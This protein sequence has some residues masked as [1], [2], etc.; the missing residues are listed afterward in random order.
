M[1]VPVSWLR[2]YVAFDLPLAALAEKLVLSGLEVD[3]IVTRGAPDV[4]GNHGTFRIGR[5]VE[6]ARHPNADRLR[7]CRV[8][9]GE[10]EPRQIVCGAANFDTG[11][12]VVVALPGALLPGATEPL[13]QA[14]LRGEVSDGMMLSERELQLSEEHDG[15]IRLPDAYEIGS[16][17][18]DH[19]ALAET[20]LEFEVTSNRSDLMCVYGI[21]RE[22]SALLD[23]ELA[24][25][26]GAL[27]EALGRRPTSALVT[28]SVDAPDRCSRFTA[29]AFDDV[30]SGGSPLRLRQRVAAA[31][32]RPISNVVDI[33]NYVMLG[34]GSPVHAYDA[35]K[36]PGR[37][38]TARLARDGEEL[39][40]LDGRHRVLTTD[41]LVIADGDGPNGLAGVMGG[42]GA[43]IG[44]GTESV[45]IE[46]ACFE[47]AGIG[48]TAAALGLRTDS[49]NRFIRGVDPHLPP[50]ASA[51]VAELLVAHA[52][53]AMLP[54]PQDV[55][56]ALP[57]RERVVLRTGFAERILGMPIGDDAAVR[58][59][60][61]LG[62]EP[63]RVDGGVETT[64]PTWRQLDTTREIDLVEEVGRIHGLDALPA[65]I[66]ARHDRGGGLDRAQR[67]RR[68]A[69]DVLAGAGLHEA[70]T[71]SIVDGDQ[72]DR[73]G[74]ASD[75]PRRAMVA[76]DNPLSADYAF[77]RRT[78]VPGLLQAVRRNR[79]SG[80]ADVALFEIAHLYHA[81][82]GRVTADNLAHEPWTLGAV[83]AGPLGGTSWVGEGRESDVFSARGVL[84][85]LC[86]RLGVAVRLE[87]TQL[88][89]LHPGRAARI[90]LGSDA[91]P[92]G[93]LGELHPDVAARFDIEGRVAVLELD[94]D[95]LAAAVPD[96]FTHRDISDQPPV[97][98]DIAVVVA[99][100]VRAGDVI[101]A[102]LEAGA[103][104]L[105]N[106]EVFDV[107]RDERRLGP[108]RVSL[109]LRLVFQDPE[110]TLVEDEASAVRAVVVQALER[111]FAAEL[112]G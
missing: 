62:Y 68:T 103:P 107:Y 36:I 100:D 46:V 25:P 9:V 49:A 75:D 23:V 104:L 70:Y 15:I 63:A 106:A 64:V 60:D 26:P 30:R 92:A 105:V 76:V 86:G 21:A 79:A 55:V 71:L 66:P 17:A 82:E 33:T 8:D 52:G 34:L 81:S 91:V 22:V 20:V 32:M 56:A 58:I 99:N 57:A 97:R 59:L 83:I 69:E 101:A 29:R 50:Q 43:E 108:G 93:E 74:L 14:K 45:V 88:A 18:R 40:T 94:L 42:E 39:T 10:A 110:R 54:K 112:R 6:W 7:L 80:R 98:Q 85:A 73:Y 72:P 44:A 28:V 96:R 78:L 90:L 37:V 84:D 27:P 16:E 24:P 2:D 38:L 5:V 65:T 102:A 13:R 109:A 111:R 31:G 95:L 1:K 61:R 19:F 3:R 89:H 48:R 11:D 67:L 12:T 47:R 53:A 87:P 35:A 51:W 41:M 4:D 77:M